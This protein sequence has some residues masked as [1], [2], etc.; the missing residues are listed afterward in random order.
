MNRLT[1][2]VNCKRQ[3]EAREAFRGKLDYKGDVSVD[4]AY[5]AVF[6]IL[7]VRAPWFAIGNIKFNDKELAKTRIIEAPR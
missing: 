7:H 2:A 6:P 1:A 4:L 5:S 3:R